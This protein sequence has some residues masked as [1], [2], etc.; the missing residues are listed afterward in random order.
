MLK[1]ILYIININRNK[2]SG[3]SASRDHLI[4]LPFDKI[5]LANQLFYYSTICEIRCLNLPKSP[6][7]GLTAENEQGFF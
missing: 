5:A 2:L 1:E 3:N 6:P 4:P 7:S